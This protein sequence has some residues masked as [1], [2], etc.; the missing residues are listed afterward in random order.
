M[1]LPRWFV[2]LGL[3]CAVLAHFGCSKREEPLLV[4]GRSH[5]T[6]RAWR[7]ASSPQLPVAKWREFD[8][9]LDEIRFELQREDP[10]LAHNEAVDAAAR[11][12]HGKTIDQALREGDLARLRRLTQMAEQLK[13]MVDTNALIVPKPGDPASAEALHAKLK[14]QQARLAQLQDEIAALQARHAVEPMVPGSAAATPRPLSREQALREIAQ[15]LEARRGTALFKYGAW[16]VRVTGDPAELPAEL[17]EDF[18]SRQARVSRSGGTLLG[19][20]IRDEWLIFDQVVE[21]PQFSEAV[22]ANLTVADQATIKQQWA[23]LEAEIW[24]RRETFEENA[25]AE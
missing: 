12:V 6:L 16:Q 3:A 13:T 19:I 1:R 21:P 23:L 10:T 17:Q 11:K 25:P 7:S 9:A 5:S 18:R 14:D 15:F 20:R 8:A 22:V 24:A 4:D 2:S